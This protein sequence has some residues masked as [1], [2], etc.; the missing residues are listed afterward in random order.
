MLKKHFTNIAA[1]V[2]EPITKGKQLL[3]KESFLVS[4]HDKE[5]LNGHKAI[6]LWFTGFSGS[7]KST[8]ARKLEKR[9]FDAGI[10]TAILDGDNT[11]M[12]INHD[13]DFS[14]AG[15]HENIRRVAEMAKLL[16]DAGVIVITSFISPFE[17][18][19]EMARN[20]IGSDCFKEIFIDTTLEI[21]IE[22]DTKGLYKKALNGDLK[23]FT[24]ISS[25]YQVP[26][27]PDLIVPTS[28]NIPEESVSQIFEWF[29]KTGIFEL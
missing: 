27:N 26:Q 16:N 5:K 8:I 28:H 9:L 23:D 10:R 12:T 13:L 6:V 29:S 2:Q 24:G 1:Q 7:G 15:R 17:S 25:P 4:R 11:R 18:D 22:R 19:R 20:I 3:S 14:A 21:C